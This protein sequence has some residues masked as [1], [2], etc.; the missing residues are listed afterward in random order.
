MRAQKT[1]FQDK[2]RTESAE[3]ARCLA[4]RIAMPSIAL[5]Y[6]ICEVSGD[7]QN[8]ELISSAVEG[9]K[10]MGDLREPMP[11]LLSLDRNASSPIWAD[12]KQ[13]WSQWGQ[14]DQVA[15]KSELSTNLFNRVEFTGVNLSAT[16]AKRGRA[17]PSDAPVFEHCQYFDISTSRIAAAIMIA[18]QN[19]AMTPA[20]PVLWSFLHACA[21]RER[22]PIVI[23]RAVSKMTFPILKVLGAIA[24]QYY[25]VPIPSTAEHTIVKYKSIAD[26]LGLPSPREAASWNTHPVGARLADILEMKA[27][28]S[29]F[30]RQQQMLGLAFDRNF[31]TATVRPTKLQRFANDLEK[32]HDVRWP[33]KWQAALA[34]W[35]LTARQIS[36][37][38]SSQ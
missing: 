9:L 8:H 11:G 37:M 7:R 35:T 36:A 23:T 16:G 32:T 2:R 33:A 38:R 18:V 27:D 13:D 1:E 17:K 34:Q 24:L 5:E 20:D 12:C 26:N 3:I 28:K 4:K 22:Q 21:E 25:F 6:R 29:N 10:K 14:I 19:H 30:A 15:T 31:G